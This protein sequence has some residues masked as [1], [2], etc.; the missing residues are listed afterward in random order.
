MH[1]V[2]PRG[3]IKA[4]IDLTPLDPTLAMVCLKSHTPYLGVCLTEVHRDLIKKELERQ[5]FQA[6][7]KAGHAL[8][9]PE[10][11]KL[12]LGTGLGNGKSDDC[13]PPE[14]KQ[15]RSK[16]TGS[17]KKATMEQLV[18]GEEGHEDGDEDVEIEMNDDE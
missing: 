5:V 11:A 10:V 4:A 16:P 8:Y 3:K 17:A 9:K 6:F 1:Q 12:L 13:G 15:R 14:K 18:M 7:L 2:G